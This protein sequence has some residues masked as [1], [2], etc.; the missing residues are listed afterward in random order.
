MEPALAAAM[1][2]CVWARGEQTSDRCF[3]YPQTQHPRRTLRALAPMSPATLYL[4]VK[5]NASRS[6]SAA[7]SI[8]SI[9]GRARVDTHSERHRGQQRPWLLRPAEAV[10][11]RVR[12]LLACFYVMMR[13]DAKKRTSRLVLSASPDCILRARLKQQPTTSVE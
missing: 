1:T 2:D 9:R 7:E 11:L 6:T 3:T 13:T 10:L 12:S 8:L 4:A 5:E